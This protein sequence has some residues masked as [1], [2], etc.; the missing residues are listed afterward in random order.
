MYRKKRKEKPFSGVQKQ[1]KRVTKTTEIADPTPSTS[2]DCFDSESEMEEPISASRKKMKLE[3]SPSDSFLESS[4]SEDEINGPN[5][6]PYIS[7]KILSLFLLAYL[8][9]WLTIGHFILGYLKNLAIYLGKCHGGF[10]CSF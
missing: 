10:F 1:A 9:V 8:K 4:E 2:R 3:S 5:R 7:I 6:P